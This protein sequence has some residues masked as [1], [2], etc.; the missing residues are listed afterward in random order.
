M[1]RAARIAVIGAGIG[2]LAAACALRERVS[3]CRSTSAP[4]SSARSA[5]G[6]SSDRT[7]SR[8]C[9]RSGSRNGCG[10]WPASRPISSRSRRT[11]GTCA[12]ASRCRRLPRRNSGR[13]I[14]PPIAPTCT[15]CCNSGCR[16]AAST[17]TPN[18][19]ACPRATARPSLPMAGRSKPTS[20]WAPTA[21]IPR[22]GKACSASSRPATRSRWPGAASC[23]SIAC[24]RRSGPADR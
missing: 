18:A 11:T 1:T 10:R 12:F 3:R 21:S 17:S 19:P 2:G 13:P 6:C 4:A 14:S 20:W 7:R 22:C 8:C 9:V 5:P 24:R 16:P 15:G 23:R